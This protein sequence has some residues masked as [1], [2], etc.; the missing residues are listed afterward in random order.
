MPS[1]WDPK[2]Q[3]KGNGGPSNAPLCHLVCTTVRAD[4]RSLTL[5]PRALLLRSHNPKGRQLETRPIFILWCNDS[6]ESALP[7]AL[8]WT[9]I[10]FKM[11]ISGLTPQGRE[12][13]A[14]RRCP[15]HSALTQGPLTSRCLFP[16]AGL[17]ERASTNW[18][19]KIC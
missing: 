19:A 17:I 3:G 11:A 10:G 2:F 8:P 6:N 4:F 7:Y 14:L 15:E 1:A 12:S 9:R 5:V 16:P 18:C 13:P